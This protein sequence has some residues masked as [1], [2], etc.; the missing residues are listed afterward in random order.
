MDP[1]WLIIHALLPSSVFCVPYPR[2][3]SAAH[4]LEGTRA[5]AVLKIGACV[6]YTSLSGMHHRKSS[7][8][9]VYIRQ[10][11]VAKMKCKADLKLGLCTKL[12]KPGVHRAHHSKSA[13]E[14][15]TRCRANPRRQS[16]SGR[17]GPFCGKGGRGRRTL[18]KF[19]ECAEGG[20]LRRRERPG[21]A[22]ESMRARWGRVADSE[23]PQAKTTDPTF[24]TFFVEVEGAG[25]FLHKYKSRPATLISTNLRAPSSG[26]ALTICLEQRWR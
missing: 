8:E 26:N 24:G 19:G 7:A 17:C 4:A 23:E 20:A 12:V 22:A 3:N 13:S 6:E 14:G 1:H 10:T 21:L 18:T 5:R 16:P 9:Y 25:R 11:R 2:L 15:F